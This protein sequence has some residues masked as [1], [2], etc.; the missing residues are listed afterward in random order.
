M[1][2]TYRLLLCAAV[3]V[4]AA[5]AGR[6][7]DPTAG[8]VLLLVNER[9]VEGDIERVGEQYRVRH[10]VG[11]TW[12]PADKVLRL[13]DDMPGAYLVLKARANLSDPDE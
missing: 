13:C 10:V 9:T 2:T 5:G 1:T 3:A 7:A 4:T 6:A 8:H 11:E 12:V